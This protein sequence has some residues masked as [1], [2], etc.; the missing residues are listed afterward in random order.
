[1]TR[2][3][4]DRLL[5]FIHAEM[6][7]DEAAYMRIIQAE[8][9]RAETAFERGSFLFMLAAGMRN[10][11]FCKSGTV[12]QDRRASSV[13]CTFLDAFNLCN[14]TIET[15][16]DWVLSNWRSPENLNVTTLGSLYGGL[17][18]INLFLKRDD[19]GTTVRAIKE[20]VFQ[21]FIASGQLCFD[22]SKE[23]VV[24][25]MLLAC[26]PFGMF[27]PEDL[28]LVE[29]VRA[30]EVKREKG[31]IQGHDLLFLAWYDFERG[32]DAGAREILSTFTEG[33]DCFYQ[34]IYQ[35]MASAGQL[36]SR[37][38]LHTPFGNGNPYVPQPNERF[39]KIIEQGDV[40]TA[41]VIAVPASAEDPVLADCGGRIRR[42]VFGQDGVW[43]FDFGSFVAGERVAYQF[44]F[45]K[46]P[47]IRSQVY[48]FEVGVSKC[49]T[50]IQKAYRMEDGCEIWLH[51]DDILIFVEIREAG[52]LN[53]HMKK[54]GIPEEV[55]EKGIK[56]S[57]EKAVCTRGVYRL[58]WDL[59][60]GE[61]EYFEGETL[62]IS[63]ADETGVTYGVLGEAITRFEC[64]F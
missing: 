5:M 47:A 28:V 1:M 59:Q 10:A 17:R 63:S 38:I 43:H 55:L 21:R 3:S 14:E 4:L 25:Q 48:T 45:E 31:E 60:T 64:R 58:E 6:I 61:F 57:G 24:P 46:K 26:A 23:T 35:K 29:G 36:E 32:D 44:Y 2:E 18:D 27:E 11:L 16:V 15:H 52:I 51:S 50:K 42:G 33:G 53:V 30:L 39:P 56:V 62:L 7:G 37:V 8:N 41:G 54:G 20:Y 40:V 22:A 34:L 12:D 19:I 13:Y 9:A 49:V